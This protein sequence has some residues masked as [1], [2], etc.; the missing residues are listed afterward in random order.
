MPKSVVLAASKIWEN[1]TVRIFTISANNKG[2]ACP[3]K[4]ILCQK[5]YCRECQIYLDWQERE[6]IVV[7]CAWCGNVMGK[8]PGLGQTGISHGMCDECLQK[9]KG[10]K[11]CYETK[12]QGL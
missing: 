1:M 7:I 3:F 8:K 10:S 4:L 6:E 9:A 12:N 2:L 11:E 5:G